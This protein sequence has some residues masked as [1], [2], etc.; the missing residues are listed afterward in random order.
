MTDGQDRFTQVEG[1]L[2]E[3]FV[4]CSA[5]RVPFAALGNALL[6]V[7]LGFNIITAAGKQNSLHAGQQLS[8]MPLRFTKRNHHRLS[9]QQIRANRN[10]ACSE[11]SIVVIVVAGGDR[12]ERCEHAWMKV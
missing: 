9:T 5:W 2:Q 11:R 3:E 12:E 4:D 8:N 1:I 6:A 7:S 10:M